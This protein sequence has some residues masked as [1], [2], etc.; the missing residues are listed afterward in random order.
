MGLHFGIALVLHQVAGSG[1]TSS[2]SKFIPD[3]AVARSIGAVDQRERV[4]I[5]GRPAAGNLIRNA[6]NALEL[7][8][9]HIAAIFGAGSAGIGC[10]AASL[11]GVQAPSGNIGSRGHG[12]T[13]DFLVVLGLS[14]G[15]RIGSNLLLR[16]VLANDTGT[17]LPFVGRTIAKVGVAD[18]AT[19]ISAVRR[20][21][22]FRGGR[23]A[24]TGHVARR[25]SGGEAPGIDLT[26]SRDQG[27]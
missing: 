11:Q 19:G 16:T 12:I 2:H 14:A 13:P 3:S 17:G 9:S 25:R 24:T 4:R 26:T 23:C 8:G 22:D 15:L 27:I 21:L 20:T 1:K 6:C 18:E 10:R 5:I 7:A